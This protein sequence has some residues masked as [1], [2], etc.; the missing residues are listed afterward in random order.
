MSI[1]ILS[2]L[3]ISLKNW[4]Y[5]RGK[6]GQNFPT[7]RVTRSCI[8]YTSNGNSAA[9]PSIGGFFNIFENFSIFRDVISGVE[10]RYSEFTLFFC[11]Y[12]SS[13]LQ[14]RWFCYGMLKNLY[15]SLTK[16][17]KVF[18]S[19]SYQRIHASALLNERSPFLLSKL[20]MDFLSFFKLIIV[21]KIVKD[22][23]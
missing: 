3:K 5:G 20:D 8:L 17:H 14:G 11:V 21:R 10:S 4:H 2:H 15:P 22:I 1:Y 18:E 19:T 12:Y 6:Y 13:T 9:S 7:I 16:K 23:D